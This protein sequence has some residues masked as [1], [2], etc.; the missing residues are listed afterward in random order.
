MILVFEPSS[1]KIGSNNFA[2][3]GYV[4]FGTCADLSKKS[5][6]VGLFLNSYMQLKG[7]SQ[8][9]NGMITTRW[10]VQNRRKH[11]NPH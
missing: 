7:M 3:L 2:N 10:M 9:H 1:E 11:S 4:I 5:T 8:V 6:M